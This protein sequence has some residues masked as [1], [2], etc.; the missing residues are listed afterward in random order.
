MPKRRSPKHDHN[1]PRSTVTHFAQI[2][3]VG[4]ATVGDFHVLGLRT[5]QDL[6]GRDPIA[7]YN[8]LCE[9]TH[10]RHDP[11]V[12]DVFIASVRYMEGAPS[13]PWYAYTAERKALL[14][15]R[16]V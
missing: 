11:C 8:T 2:P 12:I 4:P 3:N 10:Q 13:T 9:R 6:I 14:N 15:A 7:M 16:T 1:T 5:P